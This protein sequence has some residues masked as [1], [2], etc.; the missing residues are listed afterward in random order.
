MTAKGWERQCPVMGIVHVKVCGLSEPETLDAAVR[1]GADWVG[2]VLVPQSPRA[3]TLETLRALL[4]R[5]ESSVPVALLC[6]PDD[7]LVARVVEAG[8]PVIQL[9]GS[10]SPER[11]S[12]I[13]RLSGKEVWK[14]IGVGSREDVSGAHAYIEADRLLLDAKPPEGAK[15]T[16]GHGTAFDWSVLSGAEIHRPWMLAGGLTPGTV[17]SAIS[18]TGARAVDVSSGVERARGLKDAGLI[19]AFVEAAKHG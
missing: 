1:A 18:A 9:H 4:P 10:E 12:E 17:A 7:G 3:V 5:T 8:V 11:L 2:F 15:R 14:A 6:D 13:K 16:G 19:K